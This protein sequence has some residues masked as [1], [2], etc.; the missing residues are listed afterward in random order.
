MKINNKVII[1]IKNYSDYALGCAERLDKQ[2][3]TIIE[4]K[5]GIFSGEKKFLVQFDS[6]VKSWLSTAPE[7][8]CFWFEEENLKLA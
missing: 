6:P 7:I 2:T 3:G 4:E 1:N 5:F 8:V